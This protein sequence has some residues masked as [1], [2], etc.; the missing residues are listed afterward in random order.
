MGTPKYIAGYIRVSSGKQVKEGESL[1]E[2][3]RMIE[4]Y[5]KIH[6]STVYKIYS[7]EGISG[8]ISDRPAL[9]DLKRDADQKRFGKIIFYSLDRF[10]RS[11]KDLLNNYEFFEK[12]GISLLSL[13]EN[14]DTSTATG[15]F[16]RTILGAVA[17]LEREMI[18][19]RV[20]TGM[21]ARI[22]KGRKPVGRVPFGFTWD[23]VTGEFIVKPEEVKVYKAMIDLFLVKKKSMIQVA[24]ILN[25]QGYRT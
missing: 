24:G 17:E 7:D 14:I 19:E 16:L 9:E 3:R 2:Q 1:P 13:R 18:R 5:A 6:N 21:A 8:S 4:E 15:R 20:V 12:R 11:A 10:G 22:R 25:Q 23:K